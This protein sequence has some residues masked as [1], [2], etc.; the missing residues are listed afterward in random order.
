MTLQLALISSLAM[1]WTPFS[2]TTE[3][4]LLLSNILSLLNSYCCCYSNFQQSFF[5]LFSKLLNDTLG[6]VDPSCI[7]TICFLSRK[8]QI[9]ESFSSCVR[10]ISQYS[11]LV[12]PTRIGK[13]ASSISMSGCGRMGTRARHHLKGQRREFKPRIADDS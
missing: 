13:G 2:V 7:H 10:F 3:L 12:I 9:F 11:F 1:S 5:S 6:N 4:L 8:I